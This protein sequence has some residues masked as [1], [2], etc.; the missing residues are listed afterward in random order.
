MGKTGDY[1]EATEKMLEHM[2][3]VRDAEAEK[4]KALLEYDSDKIESLLQS[5]QA[6]MM[7]LEN[8][9]KKRLETEEAAG[10]SGKKPDEIAAV[11]PKEE[12]G[13][14][15]ALVAEMR[16][17]ADQLRELNR[18]SLDIA[19]TELKFLGAVQTNTAKGHG[20][21]THGGKKEEGRSGGTSFK[22][23]I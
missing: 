16:L 8:L 15:Q 14:L 13:A 10:F 12:A 5:Q 7:Q 9:E 2:K 6:V 17:V 3:L 1:I 20:L 18:A 4:R 22:E 11:L 23:K 19:Q 21:Y